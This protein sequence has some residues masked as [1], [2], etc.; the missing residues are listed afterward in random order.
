MSGFV[1]QDVVLILRPALFPLGLLF[2][3][4]VQNNVA[5]CFFLTNPEVTVLSWAERHLSSF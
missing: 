5:L 2:F 4:S 1:W 3:W